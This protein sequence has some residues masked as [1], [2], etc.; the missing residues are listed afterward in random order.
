MYYSL[1]HFVS[2]ETESFLERGSD[3]SKVTPQ[4]PGKAERG[5]LGSLCFFLLF[6]FVFF[7]LNKGL[8][9]GSEAEKCKWPPP[10]VLC[11]HVCRHVSVH[12]LT[13]ATLS[14]GSFRGEGE[15]YAVW[16]P[17]T[18]LAFPGCIPCS[19]SRH[20]LLCENSLLRTQFWGGSSLTSNS[21]WSDKLVWIKGESELTGP[22]S[23]S[24][25][26]HKH[27]ME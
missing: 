18:R 12:S 11:I 1:T 14:G 27:L 9:T 26:Y 16:G 6:C 4:V 7:L 10:W 25:L 2:H 21:S 22:L 23:L 24:V 8:L 13:P 17:Q 15:V 19:D 5:V 3:S 20:H